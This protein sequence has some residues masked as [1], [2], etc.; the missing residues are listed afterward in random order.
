[1]KNVSGIIAALFLFQLT[2]VHAQSQESIVQDFKSLDADISN[3]RT[4]QINILAPRNFRMASQYL[5]KARSTLNQQ[6]DLSRQMSMQIS[7]AN[8]FLSKAKTIAG[9]SRTKLNDIIQARRLALD[10]GADS[11]FNSDFKKAD[12]QL[13][14]LT[15]DLENNVTQGISRTSANL[16]AMYSDL[17]LKAIKHQHLATARIALVQ[18]IKEGAKF[19]DTSDYLT[20]LKNYK[21]TLGYINDHRHNVEEIRNRAQVVTDNANQLLRVTRDMAATQTLSSEQ[22]ADTQA[23]VDRISLTQSS[24]ASPSKTMSDKMA[25]AEQLFS[26]SEAELE[27]RGNTLIIH[28]KGIEFPSAQAVLKGSNLAVLGKVQKVIKNLGSNNVI[29]EG[30]TDAVGSETANR[31][32]SQERAQTIKDYFLSTNVLPTDRIKAVGYGDLYPIATNSTSKGRAQN[33]RVDIRLNF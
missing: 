1:M 30:H 33:R 20:T 7:M 27:E 28:L 22:I 10:S 8:D 14:S 15:S 4:N 25:Q 5:E 16:Q 6:N 11:F 24:V 9:S 13:L 32:L 3:S 31:L 18:A 26:S 19:Y 2:N 23:T 21:E 29:I 17:E 12:E